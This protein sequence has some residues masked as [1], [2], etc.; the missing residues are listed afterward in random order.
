MKIE[1]M[2][3]KGTPLKMKNGSF[4]SQKWPQNDSDFENCREI[5]QNRE[6][7]EIFKQGLKVVSQVLAQG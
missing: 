5:R 2:S 3:L 4:S 1:K 6:F 7:R